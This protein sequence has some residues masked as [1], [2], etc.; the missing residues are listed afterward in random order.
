MSE[1]NLPM[2]TDDFVDL[3]DENG[4]VLTAEQRQQIADEVTSGGKIIKWTKEINDWKE[5]KRMMKQSLGDREEYYHTELNWEFHAHSD[6]EIIG[7]PQLIDSVMRNI[8]LGIETKY[9]DKVEEDGKKLE[10]EFRKIQFF[11]EKFDKRYSGPMISYFTLKFF[12]YRIRTKEGEEHY[13]L[14]KEQLP[15][16][17][18]KFKGMSVDVSDFAE[19]SKSMKIGC[20]SNV[21]FLKEY[22]SNIV[23]LEPKNII[24]FTKSREITEEDWFKFLAYHRDL[25]SF[26][27][28]PYETEVLKSAHI[29][30]SK[31]D[32]WP[33]HLGIIGPQGTRKSKGFIETIAY[34]MDD[35]PDIVEGANSRIKGLTPSFKEK[36]ANLGYLAN[37]HRM[38]WVDELSKMIE[39]EMNRH[40]GGNRN[41][42]G[43][44]NFLLEHSI[45]QVS[46]GNDNT[47]TI[48]ATGKFIFVSNPISNKRTIGQHVGCLDATTMSRILWWV[49]DENEQ[50]FVLSEKG[51]I[52]NKDNSPPHIHN[53]HNTM[54]RNF[55]FIYKNDNR[56]WLSVGGKIQNSDEFLTLYDS[57]NNFKCLINEEKV[58]KLSNTITTLAKDPMKSVWKPRSQH[59]VELLI[60][61]ICKHRCMFIDYDDSFIANQDDY[62]KAERVLIR[63][64]KS[65][66]TDLSIQ[67]S[68]L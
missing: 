4:L 53:P 27:R 12:I 20:L 58:E 63:M 32:G 28:F 38:G 14:S 25:N 30:S 47:A 18:C 42:L 60:D 55:D 1:K 15:N 37:C 34:K 64:V 51:I 23:T 66:D 43:E 31:V 19:I 50:E 6:D 68:N 48:G 17:L 41:I 13:I 22:K 67:G 65:W 5:I 56:Y 16:E 26:N 57:C 24:E 2:Q 44:A 45:R 36:P 54:S 21:F 10:K 8:I 40:S 62:E 33:L 7:K 46:S 11:D 29:L 61:G 35:H 9:K 3:Y 52:K 49:Q 59:H 39:F